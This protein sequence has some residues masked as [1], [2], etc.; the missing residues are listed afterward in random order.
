LMLERKNEPTIRFEDPRDF[1]EAGPQHSFELFLRALTPALCRE[2]LPEAELRLPALRRDPQEL[3]PGAIEIRELGIR[4]VVEIRGIG[5]DQVDRPLLQLGELDR[6]R[7]DDACLVVAGHHGK[8][9][10]RDEAAREPWLARRPGERGSTLHLSHR[11]R[12]RPAPGPV[13]P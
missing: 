6:A 3:E 12:E 5:Q 1:S 8:R 10:R 2:V 11:V 7:M 9:P 13:Y 4:D